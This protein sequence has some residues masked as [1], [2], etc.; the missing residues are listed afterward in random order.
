MWPE[1][2]QKS[3]RQEKAFADWAIV[4]NLVWGNERV[5]KF[6]REPMRPDKEPGAEVEI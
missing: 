1:G 4:N 3:G 6:P 2:R 5:K